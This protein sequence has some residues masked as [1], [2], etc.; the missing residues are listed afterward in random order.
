MTLPEVRVKGPKFWAV[1]AIVSA[2]L[3][4]SS[5]LTAVAL[6]AG[7]V[8]DRWSDESLTYFKLD[9]LVFLIALGAG[10]LG[11]GTMAIS[12]F[13]DV[14]RLEIRGRLL[15]SYLLPLLC[16]PMYA[17]PWTIVAIIAGFWASAR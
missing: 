11:F 14:G 1:T 10:F 16:V 3:T 7:L 17:A 12:G 13:R 5:T 9:G 2:L 6:D 15:P 8:G 4:L